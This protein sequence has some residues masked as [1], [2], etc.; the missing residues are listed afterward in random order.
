MKTKESQRQTLLRYGPEKV[1]KKDA[2][3]VSTS[4]RFSVVPQT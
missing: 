1:K 3:I 2:K 4:F